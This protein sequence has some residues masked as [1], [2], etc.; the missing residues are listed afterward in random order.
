MSAIEQAIITWIHLVAAAIWVGG[1]LFIGIVFSPL[2]KTMTNSIEER[3]QIMIRVG[4]RFNKIAVPS[5]I[6]LMVT[7]LYTSHVLLSKPDLLVSTSYG[8]YLIIKIILVIALIITYAIHV[9]VIRKDIE[10]KIMSN[11]MPEHEIQK[12]RKKIIILGEITVV[13]SV[14]ILFFASLLDAGV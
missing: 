5:L 7:G 3:M 6:I 8:T 14:S 11:Q 10:E 1:S 12:L 13:L 2:L 4:R 9:R